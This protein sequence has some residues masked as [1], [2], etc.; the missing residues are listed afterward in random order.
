MF[1]LLLYCMY[2]IFVSNNVCFHGH[3]VGAQLGIN[4]M[5]TVDIK[6]PNRMVGL[7]EIYILSIYGLQGII[8][9][10]SSVEFVITI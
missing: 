1:E 6:I 2:V 7:G 9:L 4:Q 5:L 3:S 8:S 10:P